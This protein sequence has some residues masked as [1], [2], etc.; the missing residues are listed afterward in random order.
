MRLIKKYAI[1]DESDNKENKGKKQKEPYRIK[2]QEEYSDDFY[3]SEQESNP[4]A[5]NK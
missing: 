1:E 3:K 5:F 4:I 2:E